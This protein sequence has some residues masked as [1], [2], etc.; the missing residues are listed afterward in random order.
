MDLSTEEPPEIFCRADVLAQRERRVP[1]FHILP[2]SGQMLGVCV[3][4]IGLVKIAEAHIGP[5]RVD[6]YASIVSLFFLSSAITSYLSL[7]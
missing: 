5:S 3:T 7:R 1:A 6:E 2:A 4:L